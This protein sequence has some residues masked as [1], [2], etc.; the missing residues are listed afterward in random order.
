MGKAPSGLNQKAPIGLIP[1][2]GC[3]IFHTH[4]LTF[5]VQEICTEN[6]IAFLVAMPSNIDNLARSR[7][8]HILLVVQDA[9]LALVVRQLH[10]GL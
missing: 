5:L 1:E 7:P 4:T 2:N 8:S 10:T 6:W 3:N 9:V